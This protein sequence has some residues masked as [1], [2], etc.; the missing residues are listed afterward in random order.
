MEKTV[1][2]QMDYQINTAFIRV[3]TCHPFR[4]FSWKTLHVLVMNAEVMTL[5]DVVNWSAVVLGKI[6]LK[7]SALSVNPSTNNLIFINTC[8]WVSQREFN[9]I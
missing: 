1:G 9:S 3:V 2:I 4:C 5:L 6:I 8:S 7:K